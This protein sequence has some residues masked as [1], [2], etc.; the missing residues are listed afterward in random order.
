MKAVTGNCADDH[1]TDWSVL[2]VIGSWRELSVETEQTDYQVCSRMEFKS[3]SAAVL[4]SQTAFT[5]SSQGTKSTLGIA[6]AST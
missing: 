6:E 1:C 2:S 3:V 5:T 4:Q